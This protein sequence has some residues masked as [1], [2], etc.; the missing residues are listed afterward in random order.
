MGKGNYRFVFVDTDAFATLVYLKMNKEKVSPKYKEALETVC[1]IAIDWCVKHVDKYIV[2][3]NDVPFEMDGSRDGHMEDCRDEFRNM[4]I[5]EI[6]NRVPEDK[7]YLVQPNNIID[8]IL[9]IA[10]VVF[11]L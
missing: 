11:D 8:K 4:V 10:N 9:Y 6:R 1:G 3:P 5:S 7:I 2:L